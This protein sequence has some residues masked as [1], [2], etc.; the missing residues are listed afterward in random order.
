MDDGGELGVGVT[1]THWYRLGWP[2]ALRIPATARQRWEEHPQSGYLM[3]G[4][5][6]GPALE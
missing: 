6:R 3:T 2:N 5:A 1:A 4:G